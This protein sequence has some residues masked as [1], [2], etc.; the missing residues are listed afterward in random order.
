LPR[1]SPSGVSIRL[2]GARPKELLR[3]S[4][5]LRV[6][7]LQFSPS[8]R[9]LA[10]GGLDKMIHVWDVLKGLEVARTEVEAVEYPV[11]L[12]FSPDEG[13]IAYSP[14]M[15]GIVRLWPWKPDLQIVDLASR[16]SRNLSA[17]EWRAFAD[18]SPTP[19]TFPKLPCPELD[20]EKTISTNL[21]NRNVMVVGERARNRQV[22]ATTRMP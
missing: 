6:V 21:A 15:M 20:L 14:K 17:G 10:T 22:R 16:L 12:Q 13:R 3:G 9:Y 1:F 8:G 11:A 2:R 19:T 5:A 7:G 4:H 18:G